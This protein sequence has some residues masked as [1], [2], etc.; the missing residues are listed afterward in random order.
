MVK[1]VKPTEETIK[2]ARRILTSVDAQTILNAVKYGFFV[3]D[4]NAPFC[5]VIAEAKDVYA[6]YGTP[7]ERFC[8]ENPRWSEDRN[9]VEYEL[10]GCTYSDIAMFYTEEKEGK[11]YFRKREV[12]TS[13]N[14][15]EY[16]SEYPIE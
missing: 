9:M 15:I 12:A 2:Q 1:E 3:D 4:E 13:G 16:Y 7:C 6:R 10:S 11:L 8:V 5:D 14:L